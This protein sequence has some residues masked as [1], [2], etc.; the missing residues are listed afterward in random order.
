[1]IDIITPDGAAV[2]IKDAVAD[3]GSPE[4]L[5]RLVQELVKAKLLTAEN[6]RA[7]L[8]PQYEVRE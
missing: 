3:V 8:P 5:G 4:T 6:L 2:D 7:I 1:M